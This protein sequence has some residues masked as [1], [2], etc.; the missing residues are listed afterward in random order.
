MGTDHR[1]RSSSVVHLLKLYN[2]QTGATFRVKCF[3]N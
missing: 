3:N 2:D 1:L